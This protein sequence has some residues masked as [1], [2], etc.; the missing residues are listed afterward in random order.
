MSLET[1]HPLN[2]YRKDFTKLYTSFTSKNGATLIPDQKTVDA[3]Q[4]KI[5][6]P[7]WTEMEQLHPGWKR[8]SCST[9]VTNSTQR[10]KAVMQAHANQHNLKTEISIANDP[11]NFTA[12]ATRDEQKRERSTILSE[13]FREASCECATHFTRD[14]VAPFLRAENLVLVAN[15]PKPE[16]ISLYHRVSGRQASEGTAYA[17]PQHKKAVIKNYIDDLSKSTQG[18]ISPRP[19]PHSYRAR[20]SCI[21][22]HS[23][24]FYYGDEL[25]TDP[26][27]ANQVIYVATR[28]GRTGGDKYAT[29]ATEFEVGNERWIPVLV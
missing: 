25:T 8:D 20:G 11:R 21:G 14:S 22:T 12:F 16:D 7:A 15:R 18:K 28:N 29:E 26:A 9:G 13:D 17:L 2:S 24:G 23:A 6:E 1:R 27:Y 4:S 5:I 10:L 3:L 19:A